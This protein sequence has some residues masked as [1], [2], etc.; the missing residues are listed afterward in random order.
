MEH[1]KTFL[2]NGCEMPQKHA[3][4]RSKE[5]YEQKWTHPLRLDAFKA[6]EIGEIFVRDCLFFKPL[7]HYFR[8]QK[9]QSPSTHKDP[10]MQRHSAPNFTAV[11]FSARKDTEQQDALL[12]IR[13][14]LYDAKLACCLSTRTP[15]SL[16]WAIKKGNQRTNRSPKAQQEVRAHGIPWRTSDRFSS[17]CIGNLGFYPSSSLLNSKATAGQHNR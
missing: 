13:K 16:E 4:I 7:D 2:S 11:W 15:T 3:G 8:R 14:P 12:A 5:S 9:L 1:P 17:Q 10:Q 6:K